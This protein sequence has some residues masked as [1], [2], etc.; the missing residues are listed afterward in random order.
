M[1]RKEEAG[2]EMATTPEFNATK[3]VGGEG[4]SEIDNSDVVSS[5]PHGL[6]ILFVCVWGQVNMK[7]R[8]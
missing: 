1:R 2:Y 8:V 4:L 6:L 7:V 3:G 5:D